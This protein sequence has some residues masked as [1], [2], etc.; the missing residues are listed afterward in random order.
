M[1]RVLL[2]STLFPNAAQ[3]N[4][5]VFVENRLRATLALGGVA[6]T[7]IAPV[8]YFPSGRTMFGRYAAYARA[9]RHELRHGVDV[10]RPRYLVVPRLGVGW[11][12]HTL[13][14]AALK[15][16]RRLQAAG[17]VF[18]VID[19]HYFYP[20]GVAAARLGRA[21]RLP[22]MITGRGSDLTLLPK[23]RAARRQI[24]QAAESASAIV[25]V[26][27][28]LRQRVI[29]LG[30]APDQVRVLRNGVDLEVFA[31]GDRDAARRR[32]GLRG[33]ALL[34]VG[35]LIPRKD[36]GLTLAALR[37][38]PD[39]T[40]L[41]A[42]SGPL[43]TA[44]EGQARRLGVADRV[45][46]LGEVP[47]GALPSL[48]AAADALVLASSR[49]GW[50]NVL[51]ESMACGTPVVASDVNGSGE[52]VR[53]PAAGRLMT[54]RTP[55]GLVRALSALRADPPGRRATRSYAEQFGWGQ[56]A[57]ANRALLGAVAAA[58]YGGRA[59]AAPA[60][61]ARAGNGAGAQP[62]P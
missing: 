18:D 41:I 39:C 44:L 60:V 17:E 15:M 58:G 48:Y 54:E 23:L 33:Y 10:W 6:A 21:L 32:L 26:C 3:P 47:H 46:F 12:P 49:E 51:L 43:R 11:T 38:L 9:P 7:V 35:S 5:G 14:L 2:F 27:E 30:A 52:V 53:S 8:P 25:T 16:V 29:A 37:E 13:F 61:G 42:G 50:A 28:D 20:D 31:P 4:H 24:V 1:L 55:E 19:A 22:V 62:L 57:L 34:S 40:L 59:Q 56:V 36:H 45:R